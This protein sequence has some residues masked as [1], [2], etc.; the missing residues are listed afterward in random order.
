M[1]EGN[2]QGLSTILYKPHK[3]HFDDSKESA[4][5]S[6]RHMIACVSAGA[7]RAHAFTFH[8]RVDGVTG[9]SRTSASLLHVCVG[10]AGA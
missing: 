2:E 5:D 10:C 9:V 1:S 3:K 6:I 8:R 4:L 7:H